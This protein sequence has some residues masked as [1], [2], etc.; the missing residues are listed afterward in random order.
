[1]TRR[2]RDEVMRCVGRLEGILSL[3]APAEGDYEKDTRIMI[4]GISEVTL[5]LESVARGIDPFDISDFLAKTIAEPCDSCE[6]GDGD[7]V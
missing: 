2:E 5:W 4:D 3:I 7:D 1:M 6:G